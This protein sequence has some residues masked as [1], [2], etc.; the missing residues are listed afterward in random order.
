[1]SEMHLGRLGFMYSAFEGFNKNKEKI[2]KLKKQEIHNIFI[3]KN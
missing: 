2:K 3:K 1:M